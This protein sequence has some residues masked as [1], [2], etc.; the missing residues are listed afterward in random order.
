MTPHP[1]QFFQVKDNYFKTVNHDRLVVDVTEEDYQIIIAVTDESGT[2]IDSE[3]ILLKNH[4]SR[5]AMIANAR[6]VAQAIALDWNVTKTHY[7]F[8]PN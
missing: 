3:V 7:E 5:N 6:K 4:D 1:D 8:L 2:C